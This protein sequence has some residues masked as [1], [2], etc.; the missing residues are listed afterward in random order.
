MSKPRKKPVRLEA[1]AAEIDLI[2]LGAQEYQ[3]TEDC[4]AAEFCQTLGYG[5]GKDEVEGKIKDLDY[6]TRAKVEA[7]RTAEPAT[8]Y[9]SLAG[10]CNLTLEGYRCIDNEIFSMHIGEVEEQL[11]G[12]IRDRVM[13]LTDGKREELRKLCSEAYLGSSDCVY[14]GMD[15]RWVMSLDIEQLDSWLKRRSI[16]PKAKAEI[17]NVLLTETP[18]VRRM[19]FRLILGG[20]A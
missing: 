17:P 14:I 11:D 6:E 8:F 10:V 2:A 5:D 3:R 19:A 20:A 15:E 12:E 7:M 16:V 18:E 1:L 13:A 4:G 9:E